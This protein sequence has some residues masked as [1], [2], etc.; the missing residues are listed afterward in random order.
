MVHCS[1]VGEMVLNL[2]L[3][4]TP[5]SCVFLCRKSTPAAVNRSGGAE[6]TRLLFLQASPRKTQNVRKLWIGVSLSA[7]AVRY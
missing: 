2:L 5:S 1:G 7:V 3:S 6:K 4:S